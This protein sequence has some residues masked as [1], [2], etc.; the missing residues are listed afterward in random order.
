[1]EWADY[2]LTRTILCISAL[3]CLSVGIYVGIAYDSELLD[4][5]EEFYQSCVQM[6]WV[7]PSECWDNSVS[8]MDQ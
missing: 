2:S 5:C 6:D 1:M 4:T 8:C 7:S 3:M